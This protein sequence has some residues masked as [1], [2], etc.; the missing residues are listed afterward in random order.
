[1][2]TRVGADGVVDQGLPWLN[3]IFFGGSTWVCDALTCCDILFVPL[4]VWCSRA[5]RTHAQLWKTCRISPCCCSSPQCAPGSKPHCVR[6]GETDVERLVGQN[7]WRLESL[8]KQ[9]GEFAPSRRVETVPCGEELPRLFPGVAFEILPRG[10]SAVYQWLFQTRRGRA[11]ARLRTARG[12]AVEE[13]A[14]F[15]DLKRGSCVALSH[16]HLAIFRCRSGCRDSHSRRWSLCGANGWSECGPLWMGVCD[17]FLGVMSCLM[18]VS[19]R[20]PV[21]TSSSGLH[22]EGRRLLEA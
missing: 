1:M 21:A 4:S 9:V 17:S 15:S 19:D 10:C 18:A 20:D 5:S 12:V 22:D 7:L 3:E 11:A 8:V 14:F 2:Q 16:V 6:E 13:A